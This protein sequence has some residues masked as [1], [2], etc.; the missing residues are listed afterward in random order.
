[1]EVW[2]GIL[3]ATLIFG[4]PIGLSALILGSSIWLARKSR[5]VARMREVAVHVQLA[6]EQFHRNNGRYPD[7]LGEVQAVPANRLSEWV[8]TPELASLKYS[9]NG[10][11]YFLQWQAPRFGFILTNEKIA[12]L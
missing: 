12:E 10:Q 2:Q 1:M 5:A 3:H 4:I 9:S 6:L 11:A 8:S 7:S